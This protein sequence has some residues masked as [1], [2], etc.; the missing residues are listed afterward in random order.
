MYNKLA[1][2]AVQTEINL[3]EVTTHLPSRTQVGVEELQLLSCLW[4]SAGLTR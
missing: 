1:I 3:F 2:Y 4:H